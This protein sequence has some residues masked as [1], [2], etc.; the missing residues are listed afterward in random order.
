VK[1]LLVLGGA[2]KSLPLVRHA[3]SRGHGVVLCDRDPQNPCRALA[4]AFIELSTIDHRRIVE[5]V[6]PHG[7][8]G[9]VS[10]GS[11]V[12]AVSAARVAE[13]LGLR[14][15]PPD[16][17]FAMVRK[18]RFREFLASHGFA[19]PKSASFA[20]AHEV[21]LRDQP[22]RL[23]VIV[24]PV[25]GAGSAGVT[26]LEEWS[27]LDAAFARALDASRE[28]RALVEEFID[29]RH[30]HL[31]GGDVFVMD[32]QVR[33]W[34]L[35]NSH[36]SCASSPF[37]PTGTSFPIELNNRDRRAVEATIQRLVSALGIR[38]GGLNVELMFDRDDRLFVIELAPRN[39]GNQIP[40]LLRMAT[41]VDLIG[42]LVD[43]ALGELVDLTPR[44][45]PA[46]VANYMLHSPRAGLYREVTLDEGILPFVVDQFLGVAYGDQVRAFERATDSFGT[47]SL[48]FRSAAEEQAVLSR[49]NE[50][51]T[52]VLDP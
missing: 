43:A 14:G 40:E 36:R 30:P 29:R 50:L 48:R 25:D 42:A 21:D 44:S 7:V 3:K 52:I 13:A 4:D 27:G 9:V 5:A 1:S 38:F 17:V 39:G 23:P 41:G 10:F 34:G 32:G 20:F 31:I 11:D 47:L 45:E 15:N 6:R 37:L 16:S 49:I 19:A 51:V 18:D 26:K 33:F 22:M 35:M 28:R 24:K 12:N 2:E 8:Q 46:F